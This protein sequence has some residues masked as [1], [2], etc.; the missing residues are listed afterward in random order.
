MTTLVLFYEENRL[1]QTIE[2]KG[3]FRA[4]A[5]DP[6]DRYATLV[7]DAGKIIRM[8]NS[9]IINL[10]SNI[11]IHL[12]GVSANP[13]DG[14]LLIVGN[15]GTVLR[16]KES[17]VGV[18]SSLIENLRTVAWNATGTMALIGG[19]AGS[20][21]KYSNN[22]LLTNLG[23]ARANLR[24]VS[25]HPRK[26]CALITSNCFADEFLPSPNLYQ[27]DDESGELT[28]VNEGRVDLIGVDRHP[29]GAT[30]LFVGYD[31]VWHNGFIGQFDGQTLT[32]IEFEN[33]QVYPVAVSWNYSGDLA[34]ICTS[35][36]QQG[37]GKGSLRMWDG[38]R[39]R[40]VFESD[41]TFFSAVSWNHHG[42]LIALGSPTN[43][44]FNC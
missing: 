18:V 32:P 37:M 35:V 11:Q 16:V 41:E 9:E 5:F 44:T 29:N 12:R 24:R 34:A 23:V 38:K 22:S 15:T 3:H 6:E 26:N 10:D 39:L 13:T 28:P 4:L 33:K 43:R 17:A 8:V 21:L 27:Y 40:T 14:S 31:V 20:L 36:P 2:L 7:G 30:A 42:T 25:W 19:N 1:L